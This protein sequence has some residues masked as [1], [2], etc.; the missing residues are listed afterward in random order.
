MTILVRRGTL[1]GIESQVG[2]SIFRIKAVASE[3]F[4]GQNRPNVCVELQRFGRF[5]G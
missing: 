2:L 3:A 5:A 1:V 4:V